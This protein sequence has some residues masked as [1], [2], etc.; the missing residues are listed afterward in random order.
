MKDKVLG[1]F[2]WS[3]FFWLQDISNKLTTTLAWY[4]LHLNAAI[5]SI[6]IYVSS[7]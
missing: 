7:L 5:L 4:L 1:G 3:F 2:F 6:D